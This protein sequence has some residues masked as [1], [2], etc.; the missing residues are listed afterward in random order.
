MS[1]TT[2]TALTGY[3]MTPSQK[4]SGMVF[5][6][7]VPYG[8]SLADGAVEAVKHMF[9]G[10]FGGDRSYL[11][12]HIFLDRVQAH[13]AH[14][15]NEGKFIET[16]DRDGKISVTSFDKAGFKFRKSG[17]FTNERPATYNFYLKNGT[18]DFISNRKT[19]LSPNK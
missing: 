7:Q 18:L 2:Q 16:I 19:F 4:K 6:S 5:W 12:G 8:F 9:S 3:I 10:G 17:G 1:T 13:I 14:G 11:D 15:W